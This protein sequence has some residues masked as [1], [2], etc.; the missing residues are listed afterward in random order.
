MTPLTVQVSLAAGVAESALLRVMVELKGLPSEAATTPG[1]ANLLEPERAYLE[2]SPNARLLGLLGGYEVHG[3]LGRGGMGTVFQ[4]FDPVLRRWVAIK[5][6]GTHL[7]G[8]PLHRQ[9]FLREA[10][11]AAAVRHANVVAVHAVEEGP[12]LPF[13]VMEYVEGIS[14]QDWLDRNT[15]FEFDTVLEITCQLVAG[16]AAAHACGLVHRDIKPAN[17]L[18]KGSAAKPAEERCEVK[19]TDF[20]LARTADDTV[21]TQSGMIAGTPQYMAPEQARGE[22]ADHRADLFSL[23]SVLYALCTG[24][25]PFT[26]GSAVATLYQVCEETPRPVR[27]LNPAVPDW[28]AVLVAKLHAKKPEDRFPSAAAVAAWL[29]QVQAHRRD[30]NLPMPA[31]PEQ[32]VDKPR[33]TPELQRL[34]AEH[35]PGTLRRLVGS[36]YR[37]Q[38]TLW[39]WPLVHVATG[40]D[41]A[42]GKVRIARGVIAIGNLAIGA[43][44]I[45]GGAVGLVAIGGGAIGMISLGG[46]A[47]GLLLALGGGAIGAVAVGGGAIGLVAVGGG[48]IGYYAMGGGAWGVHVLNDTHADPQALRFF[49]RWLGGWVEQIWSRPR[50]R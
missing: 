21:L 13:L 16:L 24:R 35:A 22:A 2:P 8:N 14:L 19:I 15:P 48:A 4:A 32:P 7:A 17:I 44:A 43:I 26:G 20:G 42:T 30:A 41:L 37:S 36:E 1:Q 10:R 12:G 39:G 46:L 5:V 34:V 47:I 40:Y 45:G 33:W 18:L 50:M 29:H 11:S 49:A 23:G 6:L 38:R 27:E 9:R 25:P 31:L 3:V 28:F